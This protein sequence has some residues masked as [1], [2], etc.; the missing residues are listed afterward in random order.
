M[1]EPEQLG[2]Y[3]IVRLLGRGGMGTVHEGIDE[4]HDQRVAIKVLAPQMAAEAGFRERFG[5][6][7]ETLKTL[8][9]PNIVRLY[10]FGEQDGSLFYAMELVEGTNLED[11]LKAGRQF[12]WREA[13]EIATQICKALKH[14]HDHGVIHRDIKP[15]NLLLNEN[16]EVKLTDFGIARL[17]GNVGMTADGGILGT[18]EYMAP[19]QAD[20]RPVTHHCDLYSLGG[21]LYALLSGRAPF[22]SSSLP[23]L[24]HMQRYSEP[25]PIRRHAVD[26]PA[27]LEQIIDR[28]LAKDPRDR[29]PNAAVVAR[30]LDDLRNSLSLRTEEA[31][32]DFHVGEPGEATD[33]TSFHDSNSSTMA[34]ED[35][36]HDKTHHNTSTPSSETAVYTA[37]GEAGTAP[38][39][40]DVVPIEDHFTRVE[41]DANESPEPHREN[42]WK[43]PQT[44]ILTLALVLLVLGAWYL[45]PRSADELFAHIQRGAAVS[46]VSVE[47]D[48][49]EF[50][51]RFPLDER[52][53]KLQQMKL[54]LEAD[55]SQGGE[56][57]APDTLPKDEPMSPIEHAYRAAVREADTNP[58]KA[59]ASFKA[60]IDLYGDSA[61]TGSDRRVIEKATESIERLESLTAQRRV[62]TIKLVEQRL[63][64][65]KKIALSD[66][67]R[68]RRIYQA[69]IDLY[70]S[71]VWAKSVVDIAREAL[72]SDAPS[73]T[74]DSRE[75]PPEDS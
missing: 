39:D 32:K 30:K 46:V 12:D 14:A 58:E 53:A 5:A 68:S 37:P 44:W 61:E 11:E 28:L 47:E 71:K 52:T 27:E 63:E 45:K 60:L 66:P 69:V 50:L 42:V 8:S 31:Q 2:P 70:G 74:A 23:E 25:D 62:A 43:S 75:K 40:A 1:K 67:K 34:P 51:R 59:I 64:E 48:I 56:D 4:A 10:A 54:K 41:A 55:R 57:P 38:S 72:K 9:H 3:R 19:E 65:A 6:E 17:F 18:A 7:I 36:K 13:T 49:D 16:N 21:V 73:R 26:T 35:I 22:R 29:Y 33:R 24:L 20:G 15:A